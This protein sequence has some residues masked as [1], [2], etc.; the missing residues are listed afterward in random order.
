MVITGIHR[1]PIMRLNNVLVRIKI[2]DSD[3][4]MNSNNDGSQPNL[5][6]VVAVSG[7]RQET[8]IG[9]TQPGRQER[10][11]ARQTGTPGRQ[12]V[13]PGKQPRG[14]RHQPEEESLV[15]R[16]AQPGDREARIERRRRNNAS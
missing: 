9:D 13:T 10:R 1:S 11:A 7:N 12:Q 5:V 6:R 3:T 14:R 4:I 2:D 16:A 15:G 8:Q